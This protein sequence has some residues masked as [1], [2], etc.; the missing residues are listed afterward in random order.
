MRKVLLGSIIFIIV[1]L[2]ALWVAINTPIVVK[3]IAKRYAPDYAIS[4]EDISGDVLDGIT[5][6]APK[7]KE[8]LLAKQLTLRLNPAALLQKKISL[9]KVVLEEGN[10]TRIKTFIES[11][12][13]SN[14]TSESSFSFDVGMEEVHISLLP[15]VFQD[16]SVSKF[17]MS[18]SMLSYSE[19][20]LEMEALE[21][22]VDTNATD[23]NLKGSYEDREVHITS[24]SV[25]RVDLP[26]LRRFISSLEKAEQGAN[27]SHEETRESFYLPKSIR[28]DQIYLN[29]KPTIFDPVQIQ[30]FNLEGS[31]ITVNLQE[32]LVEDGSVFLDARSNLSNIVFKGNVDENTLVGKIALTPHKRLFELSG[33]PLRKEAFGNIVIDI[34]ASTSNI[35]ADVQASAT[36]ILTG[37]KGDFNVDVES[38][39]SKVLYRISEQKLS[40]DTN[41][42]LSTPYAKNILLTNQLMMNKNI[43]Y[44]GEIYAREVY[45]LDENLTGVLHD[46]NVTYQGDDM[47]LDAKLVSDSLEGSFAMQDYK[48]GNL[49]LKTKKAIKVTDI[50]KLP[51]E[52]EDTEANIEVQLP[53]DL[54]QNTL[55]HGIALIRS[56][57]VN[58]DTDIILS[59]TIQVK[60]KITIPE[61]SLVRPL[62]PKI[63]WDKLST[64]DIDLTVDGNDS[65]IDMKTNALNFQ[66]IYKKNDQTIKGGLKSQPLHA[67]FDANLTKELKVNTTIGSLR[68]LNTFIASYYTLDDMPVV[69]GS[70]VINAVI[71]KEKKINLSLK[72]PQIVYNADRENKHMF[73]DVDIDISVKDMNMTIQHYQLIYNKQRLYAT[74]PS[75]IQLKDNEVELSSVWVND[76]LQIAG[77]YDLKKKEGKIN[78]DANKLKL[79]HEWADVLSDINIVTT[80]DGNRT[81]IKG[82]IVLQGGE[83]HYD[84]NQQSFASDSDIIIVENKEKKQPNHFM[85]QLSMALNIHCKKAL[86]FKQK[87]INIQAKPSFTLYKAMNEPLMVLGSIELLEG[88]TYL[89]QNKKF[90]LEKSFIYFTGTFNK[91]LLEIKAK[92]QA[93]NHLITITVTGTP[94]APNINFSS[95]PSLTRE[96]ILS[97]LLFDNESASDT[98]TGDEMMKMMG[99]AMAK[100]ALANAGVKIDHFVLGAGNS[101]EVGKKLTD[102][103]MII[104]INDEIPRVELKYRHNRRF[105]SV[106]GASGESSSYDIIYIKDF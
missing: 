67:T 71:N 30:K 57:L 103:L 12:G 37:K 97:V 68:S 22:L 77:K 2:T 42:T 45:G 51:E 98:Y 106:I 40:S 55:L 8:K 59:K 94:E 66:A 24:L 19:N 49:Q 72:S 16:I 96:Q 86:L 102:D 6:H 70:A 18:A 53:F 79:E 88:G 100:S 56:N 29:A 25:K 84:I 48:R 64:I 1:L 13:S 81:D 34:L 63:Q 43:T 104:Y 7:Y 41:I 32:R 76:A 27:T 10:V 11:F 39:V 91:P 23:I 101:I 3:E 31:K 46:L 69:E 65:T 90:V 28:V 35:Q 87:D 73:S 74:K 85:D 36:Q 62:D 105:Q 50:K 99:G 21:L 14:D 80:A 52:L 58:V 20:E 92:H 61:D 4:Y 82:D 15:F 33:L 54:E 44:H 47:H 93:L 26:T 95:S 38:L 75:L 89:F 78:A 17:L 60:N 9:T 83:I 5:I